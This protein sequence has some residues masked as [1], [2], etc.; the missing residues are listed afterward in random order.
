MNWA[1]CSHGIKDHSVSW[2][3]SNESSR[4][5][6]TDSSWINFAWPLGCLAGLPGTVGAMAR[7]MV[8]EA[9]VLHRRVRFLRNLPGEFCPAHG[10][11]SVHHVPDVCEWF[12]AFLAWT[13]DAEGSSEKTR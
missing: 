5:F 3:K 10:L 2:Q 13:P 11:R 8:R 9:F 7:Q 1:S 12:W 4:P 6:V